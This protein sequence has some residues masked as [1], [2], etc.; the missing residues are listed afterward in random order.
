MDLVMK[1][2]PE[3]DRA[4]ILSSIAWG[5]RAPQAL[6]AVSFH[7]LLTVLGASVLVVL[8][9]LRPTG[10]LLNALKDR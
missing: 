3:L 5:A 4:G 1:R 7:T 2:H 6:S 10:T 9:G 8:L